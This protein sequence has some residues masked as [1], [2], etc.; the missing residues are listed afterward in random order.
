VIAP[1]YP[2]LPSSETRFYI[3]SCLGPE[4]SPAAAFKG[5]PGTVAKE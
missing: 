4:R 1:G 2:D 3:V 5:F